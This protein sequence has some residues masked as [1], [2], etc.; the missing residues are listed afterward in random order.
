VILANARLVNPGEIQYDSARLTGNGAAE[1]SANS[2]SPLKE[3]PPSA[4]IAGISFNFITMNGL[5]TFLI[6]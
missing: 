5:A 4:R 3:M 2:E 1:R 6:W